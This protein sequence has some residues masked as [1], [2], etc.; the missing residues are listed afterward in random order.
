MIAAF[1]APAV[2]VLMTQEHLCRAIEFNG[3]KLMGRAIR[4][5]Y[6]QPKKE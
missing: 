4:I 6:A 2:I 3:T 1:C 5:G